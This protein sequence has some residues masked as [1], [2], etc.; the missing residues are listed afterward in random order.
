MMWQAKGKRSRDYRA[1]V[2]A[3]ASCMLFTLTGCGQMANGENRA[4]APTSPPTI[5][6]QAQKPI[7]SKPVNPKP[8][9][10]KPINPKVLAANTQFGFKLFSE[11]VRQ[12]PDQNVFVSPTSVAIA[13]AMTYN[14]AAGSTQLAMAKALAF[15]GL[16]LAD[17]NQ[18]NADLKALLANPESQ[19]QLAIANSL[20]VKQGVDFKSTFINRNRQFYGAQ[21]TDLDFLN[22]QSPNQINNWVKENTQGKI[23]QIVDRLSPEDVMVL[24]N[25]IYFKGTWTQPFEP[26]Q[27]SPKPFYLLNGQ[28]KNHPLMAQSGSYKYLE[29]PSFQAVSLPYGQQRRFSLDLFLPK[30]GSSLAAFHK[31]LTPESWKTWLAQFRTRPGSVQIPRFKL[32]YSIQLNQVLSALGMGVA[33]D[34]AQANFAELSPMPTHIDRVQH[35]TFVDVNETGTEAAATT[36]VGVA[37]TSVPVDPPFSFVVDRPFFCAIRDRQTGTILFMGAIVEPK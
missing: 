5:A 31:T 19:V 36:A 35:K 27:T 30:P 28:S 15:Q 34:Q 16:K 3:I 20:W 2:L 12:A 33:F 24:V 8:A 37:A 7:N 32:E 22:P 14:G 23:S 25:A 13:L 26:S 17:I 21:V 18:A 29:T 1:G 4:I 9:T 10:P 6:V 11:I